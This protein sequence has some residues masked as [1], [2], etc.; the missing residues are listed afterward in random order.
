MLSAMLFLALPP[1]TLWA[2]HLRISIDA[3]AQKT[4]IP[5][6]LAAT[7]IGR[8][9]MAGVLPGLMIGLR[10]GTPPVVFP[11]LAGLVYDPIRVGVRITIVIEIGQVTP[12]VGLN[13]SVLSSLTR[14]EISLGRVA[15]ATVPCRLIQ[16][17]APVVLTIFPVIAPWLPNLLF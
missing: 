6:A 17:L 1:V 10:I 8:L 3:D 14:N 7:S 12:P 4:L 5:V 15:T 11:P 16:P 2:E 13:L 9:F